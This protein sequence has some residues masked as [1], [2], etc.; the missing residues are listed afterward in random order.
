[1][2]D[3]GLQDL[4][5][6]ALADAPFRASRE[7]RDRE[8][9]DAGRLERFARFLAR[10]FYYERIVHFFKYSRSLAAVTRRRPE[11][12]LRS[13]G[14]D[15]LLA[16]AVLGSRE[17]ARAVAGTVVRHVQ[18]AT[19]APPI[20]YLSDLLRYEQGMMI[21][22]AGPRVWR[23]TWK[24]EGERGKGA[25]PELVEGTVLLELAFDL[26]TVLPRLLEPWTEV[27]QAPERRVK[28]LIA[29]S[30]HG[31]VTVARADAA[32]AS[33]VELADGRKT[34]ADLARQ[35]GLRAADL[36]AALASLADL[37]AVRFATGS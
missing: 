22:E 24:G 33:V 3:R 32:V 19:P 5:L 37:G 21:A 8:L 31:R 2:S 18:A 25:P 11:A 20:P 15:A 14:F 30:P 23:E 10:H 36:E 13:A 4:V 9:A 6:R 16:T 27:P 12:V 17:T 29:R 35:A 28:L 26:P 1:M 7:W 34:L